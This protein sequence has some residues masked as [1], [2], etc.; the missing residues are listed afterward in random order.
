M[1]LG[2]AFL[3]QLPGAV[4]VST[5]LEDEHDGRHAGHGLGPDHLG[6]P[7]AVQQV[8]L[9]RNRDELLDLFGGEPERLCLDLR[10]RR[11]ELR[12]DVHRRPTQLDDSHH[13]E[14]ECEPEYQQREAD[15]ESD[16]RWDHR[17]SPWRTTPCP[18]RRRYSMGGL[19]S[20]ATTGQLNTRNGPVCKA[21]SSLG[22]AEI[23]SYGE[24]GTPARS[25]ASTHPRA[26]TSKPEA[27][28][29]G[30]PAR[31]HRC[32]RSPLAGG[33]GGGLTLLSGGRGTGGS[34]SPSTSFPLPG[35]TASRSAWHE[36]P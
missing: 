21:N 1:R 33:A 27:P 5:G 4:D 22:V 13:H 9:Q 14:S 31:D 34:P 16:N 35:R 36:E 2:Q 25:F 7:H 28:R 29:R 15:A 24:P 32:G 19:L 6:A 17:R 23:P 8:G 30:P 11:A 3:D 12:E 20:I 10:V 18:L 26:G